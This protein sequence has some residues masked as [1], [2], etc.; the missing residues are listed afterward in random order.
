MDCP[1]H[2]FFIAVAALDDLCCYPAHS[3][4]FHAVPHNWAT[5][6]FLDILSGGKE[7]G[8]D[9]LVFLLRTLSTI[10]GQ[11]RSGSVFPNDVAVHQ[12][13]LT[14][15]RTNPRSPAGG[16]VGMQLRLCTNPLKKSFPEPVPES[17]TFG[18]LLLR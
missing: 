7:L 13:A 14:G 8:E 18:P 2:I 1:P 9:G 4:T 15:T 16:D 5:K 6:L 10:D 12:T 11:F 17:V 3:P